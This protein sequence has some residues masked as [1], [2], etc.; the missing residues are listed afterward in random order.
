M[1]MCPTPPLPVGLG[2]GLLGSAAR[3]RPGDRGRPG[4]G[5]V[6]CEGE[7]DL[8]AGAARAS[9]LATSLF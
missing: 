5:L 3:D 1:W 8:E 2:V 4:S 7:G 9:C 6:S